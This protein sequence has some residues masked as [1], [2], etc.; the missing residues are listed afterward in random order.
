[1][2]NCF[3]L[4]TFISLLTLTDYLQARN[5][6]S[7][8]KL[9]EVT[10]E[11]QKSDSLKWSIEFLNRLLN[12]GGEWYLTDQSYRSPVKGILD[13]AE[14]EPVDTVV[15]NMHKLLSDNIVVYIFDRRPQNIKNT[16]NI[17][18]YISE[19][20]IQNRIEKLRIRLT[21]SLNSI[22]IPVPPVVLDYET[23]K[24]PLI[25]QGNFQN[26][27]NDRNYEMPL[28][29]KSELYSRFANIR[30]R[31]DL[32][33]I[34]IDSLRNEVFVI[35]RKSYNDS[36]LVRWREMAVASY[37]NQYLADY[38]NSK[39]ISLKNQI[40][41]HNLEVLTGYNDKAV[42][43]VNDSL[44]YALKYLTAHAETDSTLLRLYNLSG[45]KSEMWTA[46]REMKPIRM[47]IKNA[48][49]DSLS[50]V[51]INQGKAGLRLVIDDN[52]VFTRL[53]KAQNKEITLHTEEPERK[54]QKINIPKPL[55][56]PWT[57]LG[58]ASVGFTQTALS[59]W[60]KGGESSLALLFMGKY[61]ANYSKDKT[62]WENSA[63]LRYGVNQTKSRGFEKNDNKIE[64]QSRFGYS[65]FK[66]WFYSAEI[67]FKT[68]MAPGYNYPDKSNPISSFMAPGYLTFALGLDYKPNKD[69]SLFISPL[70]SK[71]TYVRDTTSIK[72]K[73]YGLEP[74]TKKLWEP[75]TIIKSAWHKKLTDNILYDTKEEFFNNYRYTFEKFSFDWEQTLTMQVNHYLSA[76]IRT[77]L[78]YDYNTKF[79][80]H[81]TSGNEIGRKPMWQ[82]KELFNIGFNYKF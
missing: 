23:S 55:T 51:L 54:L 82:F 69:F 46:N 66:H 13:Y 43:S 15:V 12:S 30:F 9:K 60:A 71:T 75:G 5:S 31:P 37:R 56:L 80:V 33:G 50:V 16:Q 74:G 67:N 36:V 58:N 52:V 38:L 73:N 19:D 61:T 28:D 63:E 49:N 20:Y 79:P 3:L 40:E 41:K 4:L 24:A 22:N 14:D 32:S 64:I 8:N 7:E 18:G 81:D 65:A 10:N 57:L 45:E 25:P 1:M 78:I 44:K 39:V 29:F 6:D 77:E 2:K 17:P 21:D 68:Q 35:Y 62:R 53:S 70:T 59:N 27:L 47:Y 11:K 48:Q 42:N 34:S 76:M 26:V 72:P